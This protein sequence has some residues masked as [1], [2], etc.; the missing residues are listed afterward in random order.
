VNVFLLESKPIR[1]QRPENLRSNIKVQKNLR[2][3]VVIDFSFLIIIIFHLRI[4]C[5]SM[6][7]FGSWDLITLGCCKGHRRMKKMNEIVD[8]QTIIA[9]T[10]EERWRILIKKMK[11]EILI[12][13]QSQNN[14]CT[15]VNDFN[16]KLTARTHVTDGSIF[17]GLKWN[18]N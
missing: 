4:I 18:K 16:T 12:F 2:A 15:W 8:V 1:N 5:E 13:N 9:E 7:W 10:Y 17:K 14:T 3:M 6:E 11:E